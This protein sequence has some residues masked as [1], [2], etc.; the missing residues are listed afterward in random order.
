MMAAE[1]P[2]GAVLISGFNRDIA[3]S[4]PERGLIGKGFSPVGVLD[5][6]EAWGRGVCCV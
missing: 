6:S 1:A 5:G 4:Y 3:D 2:G